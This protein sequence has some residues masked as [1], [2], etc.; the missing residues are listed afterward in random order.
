MGTVRS[1]TI[2]GLAQYQKRLSKIPGCAHM[3]GALKSGQKKVG[4]T[5]FDRLYNTVK[6]RSIESGCHDR[7]PDVCVCVCV[8]VCRHIF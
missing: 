2:R 6:D 7:C 5:S 1:L 8:C 3:H 4:A